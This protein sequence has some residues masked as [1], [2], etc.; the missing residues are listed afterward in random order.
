MLP[1]FLSRLPMRLSN[2]AIRTSWFSQWARCGSPGGV[3]FLHADDVL[4]PQL[5]GTLDAL[6]LP[7]HAGRH[8]VHLQ[9]LV[10]LVRGDLGSCSS[11]RSRGRPREAAISRPSGRRAHRAAAC[12]GSPCAGAEHLHAHALG[13]PQVLL[14]LLI[15]ADPD[16]GAEPLGQRRLSLAAQERGQADQEDGN[17]SQSDHKVSC[18]NIGAG[19]PRCPRGVLMKL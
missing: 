4:H 17:S 15:A 14:D 5:G 16:L 1:R 13:G 19:R 11:P 3:A 10:E 6:E 9:K 7:F 18:A 2:I 8:H 12:S